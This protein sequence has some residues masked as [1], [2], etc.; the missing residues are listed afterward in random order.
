[1]AK[2]FSIGDYEVKK[3]IKGAIIALAGALATYLADTIPGVDFGQYTL[4]VGMVNSIVVNALQLWVSNNL[5][6]Y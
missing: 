6:K 3:I 1:M 5:Y 4:F 2:S